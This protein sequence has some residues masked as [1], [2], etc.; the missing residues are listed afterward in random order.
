MLTQMTLHTCISERNNFF[1][2][3]R[4]RWWREMG[5]RFSSCTTSAGRGPPPAL[6]PPPPALPPPPPPAAAA[7][8]AAAE[9]HPPYNAAPA[10][11]QPSRAAA[12]ASILESL[13]TPEGTAAA[14]AVRA[15][16]VRLP[17][18]LELLDACVN[19]AARAALS[20]DDFG[21]VAAMLPKALSA[22][23]SGFDTSQLVKIRELFDAYDVDRG[24]TLEINELECMLAEVGHEAD[25]V[26]ASALLD[27]FGDAP[28]GEGGAGARVLSFDAFLR[29]AAKL[30]GSDP[31]ASGAD[32][33]IR[34]A[35][36]ISALLRRFSLSCAEATGLAPLENPG[37]AF[38][39]SAPSRNASIGPDFVIRDVVEHQIPSAPLPQVA[40]LATTTV[41]RRRTMSPNDAAQ[42]HSGFRGMNSTEN[43]STALGTEEIALRGIRR[44]NPPK[45]R[46]TWK[47]SSTPTVLSSRTTTNTCA[48]SNGGSDKARWPPCISGSCPTD[49]D[50]QSKRCAR[51]WLARSA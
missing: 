41:Q 23:R 20:K 16:R 14:L 17:E 45:E 47:S 30:N 32:E 8:A 38:N 18:C 51:A 4:G 40:S 13:R 1:C 10:S 31:E 22:A 44:K 43:S 6:P 9:D 2:C 48:R 49:H 19:Q 36:P 24:G 46:S 12:V 7:T 25:D 50:A 5:V 27:E 33:S 26:S 34:P 37:S 29:I 11:T 28:H 15:A 39:A 35:R 21:F 42:V 3:Q